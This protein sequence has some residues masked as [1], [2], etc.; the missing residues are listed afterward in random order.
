MENGEMRNENGHD[1]YIFGHRHIELDLMINRHARVILLGDLFRT[2]T[3][4]Q[5]DEKGDIQLCIQEQNS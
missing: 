4:A 3:Y 5:M 1:Y 2:F